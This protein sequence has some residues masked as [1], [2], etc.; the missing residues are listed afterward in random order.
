MLSIKALD[1]NAAVQSDVRSDIDN[2]HSWLGQVESERG[3]G[4]VEPTRRSYRNTDWRK[5]VWI[6]VDFQTTNCLWSLPESLFD[7]HPFSFP[8]LV[9]KRPVIVAERYSDQIPGVPDDHCESAAQ[10]GPA[11]QAEDALLGHQLDIMAPRSTIR[12]AIQT[13]LRR[14]PRNPR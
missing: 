14:I 9:N 11:E 8:P 2:I 1:E 4:E 10:E 6:E 13:R 3:E 12:M 5:I 7:L